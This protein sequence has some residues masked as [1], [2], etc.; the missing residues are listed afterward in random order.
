MRVVVQVLALVVVLAIGAATWFALEHFGAQPEVGAGRG[1]PGGFAS[2]VE[3]VSVGTA[4][5][6]RVAV[7]VGNTRARES[8]DV[9]AEVPGRIRAILVE[10]GQRVGTGQVLFELD[11]R[12]EEA[13]VREL[14]AVV[15]DH[16]RRLQRSLA[17]LQDASISE[18]QVDGDRAAL[19]T[20]QARLAAAEARFDERSIR[21]PFAGVVGL[22]TV[23]TGAY[24]TPGTRLTTLDDLEALRLEFSV[25][26]RY[27]SLL[28]PGLSVVARSTGPDG[29]EYRGEVL[30]VATR[31]DP[32]S[33]SVEVQ[34]E[35]PNPDGGLLP[36]M[37]MTVRLVL[38]RNEE[39]VMVPEEA[40]VPQSERMF[41]FR[42]VGDVVERVAVVVGQRRDGLVEVSEGLAAG[43][44]VVVS[45]VQRLRDGAPVRVLGGEPP[46][47]PPGA[48][49]GGT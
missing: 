20:A 9:V 40:L 12:T 32:V 23:S 13:D 29:Q 31:V 49:R 6:E 14:R 44:Q 7:A 10:E 2:P 15:S 45:G 42:L 28:A 24:V 33:R 3:V 25:P 41:V 46:A 38:G 30:R 11:R 16:E 19:E 43:D 17:L 48:G 35:L 22:R 4:R 26:E 36:G 1:G 47:G 27:L 39:A 37:F 18:A 21:A 34:S 8:I 5:L